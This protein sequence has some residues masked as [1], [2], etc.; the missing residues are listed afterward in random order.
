MIYTYL[1][2]LISIIYIFPLP[3]HITH[4]RSEAERREAVGVLAQVSQHSAASSVMARHADTVMA[5]ITGGRRHFVIA[6]EDDLPLL[7]TWC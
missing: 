1:I 6:C 2:I 7:Q 5:A 4:Y 3:L